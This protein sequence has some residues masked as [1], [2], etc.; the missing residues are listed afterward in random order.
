ML[1][2]AI[3]RKGILHMPGKNI[4]KRTSKAGMPP[5]TVMYTGERKVSRV[6]IDR[7][8][9]NAEDYR[10]LEVRRLGDFLKTEE[11]RITWININGLHDTNIIEDIS[12]MY[13][14]HPL[15][16]E[17]I[18]NTDQRPKVDDMQDYMFISVDMIDYNM[19]DAEMLSE[20]VSIVLGKNFVITFQ[21]R[22]GDLFDSIRNRIR[23]NAGR[24]RKKGSDYLAYC[25]VDVIVDHY[26]MVLERIGDEIEDIE[27]LLVEDMEQVTLQRLHV[28]KRNLIFL[29]KS[30]WPLRE[31]AAQLERTDSRHI[32]ADTRMFLR[33]VTDHTLQVIDTLETYRDMVSGLFDIYMTMASNRMNEVMKV[34]TIIATIFIPLTFIAGVYGMNFKYMPELE[35]KWGY[36]ASVAIMVL[37]AIVML[38][39]FKKKRWL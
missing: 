4:R 27:L 5:G 28:M 2:R 11:G 30:L 33:D 15:T 34:L 39:Y 10:E 22:E 16:Q 12:N 31:V 24:V 37:V 6:T 19:G 35:W 3:S 8:D 20:Q 32:T 9:Y 23:K 26:F 18:V 36:P 38:Y 13:G 7:F 25:L 21:E 29:R 1:H 17:D 14:I